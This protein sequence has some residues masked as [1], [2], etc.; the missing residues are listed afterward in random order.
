MARCLAAILVGRIVDETISNACDGPQD[1][2]DTLGTEAET[3][4]LEAAAVTARS[5]LAEWLGVEQA[6]RGVQRA[7]VGAI[8]K[9]GVIPT[10]MLRR[11]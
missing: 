5:M 8:A 9:E 7:I 2:L 4:A 1:E 3:L 6:Y 11:G 10:W